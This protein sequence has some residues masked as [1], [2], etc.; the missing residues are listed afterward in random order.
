MIKLTTED[1]PKTI[2]KPSPVVLNW[3]G[4]AFIFSAH[5]SDDIFCRR[6]ADQTV[7]TVLDASYALAPEYPFPA[8]VEDVEDLILQ[9]LS[10]PDEYDPGNIV[11]SGFSSGANL[12]LAAAGN[13]D[14]SK[15]PSKAIRAVLVFY[16]PTNMTVHPADKKLPDGSL[17]DIPPVLRIMMSAF[18]DSY[19]SPGVDPANPRLSVIN[20][21]PNNFPDHMLVITAEKDRLTPDAEELAAKLKET[22]KQ[23]LLK[24]FDGVRHGWDKTRD[25]ESN[26]AKVRDEAYELVIKFL[27]D[28]KQ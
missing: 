18:R 14:H 3:Y 22:G 12:A 19:I 28:I 10:Q 13:P 23:V 6:V 15:I 20:A 16:P 11:L 21:D 27:S 7:Y 2:V 17:P 24:R 8:A 26:E 4:N 5:G 25:E 1:R 9:V